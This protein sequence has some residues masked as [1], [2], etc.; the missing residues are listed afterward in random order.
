MFS[1]HYRNNNDF[2]LKQNPMDS[3][4]GRYSFSTTGSTIYPDLTYAIPDTRVGSPCLSHPQHYS[5]KSVARQPFVRHP[6]R[7]N[8]SRI[9]TIFQCTCLYCTSEKISTNAYYIYSSF[10]IIRLR[11]SGALALIIIVQ[12]LGRLRCVLDTVIKIS[13]KNNDDVCA[14]INRNLTGNVADFC[15]PRSLQVLCLAPKMAPT[16][17][18]F[19]P[20]CLFHHVLKMPQVDTSDDVTIQ[21]HHNLNCCHLILQPAAL[22]L[23]QTGY[24]NFTLPVLCVSCGVS[25]IHTPIS[26]TLPVK[27]LGVHSQEDCTCGSE[28]SRPREPPFYDTECSNLSLNAQRSSSSRDN[29]SYNYMNENVLPHGDCVSRDTTSRT[30]SRGMKPSKLLKSRDMRLHCSKNPSSCSD[31]SPRAATLSLKQHKTPPASMRCSPLDV[32]LLAVLLCLTLGSSPARGAPP[33]VSL[34]SLFPKSISIND[35][36]KE[37]SSTLLTFRRRY[38]RIAMNYTIKEGTHSMAYDSPREILD[39]FCKG[40]FPNHVITL[41]NINNPLGMSRRT[42][43]N[44][45]ILKLAEFLGLPII[46]WDSEYVGDSQSRTVQLAPTIEHQAM[47]MASLLERYNW[48]TFT[49]ITTPVAGHSQFLSSFE[50]IV[51]ASV[52]KSLSTPA[53][54]RKESLEILSTIHIREKSEIR[55]QLSKVKGTD[56]RIFLLHSSSVMTLEIIE[57]ANHLE[58][59]GRDYV[60]ILT[61]TAIPNAKHVSKSF[62]IGLMGITFEFDK[63]AMKRV[64]RWG[65]KLWLTA[66]MNMAN[67]RG[68]LA[69]MTIPPKFACNAT[70]KDLFWKDGEILY[71]YMLNASVLNEPQLVFN[72]NGTLTSTELIILNLQWSDRTT[73]STA[74]REVGRWQG[75]GLKMADITWPGGSSVPPTGRPKKTFLRVATLDEVPYVIYRMPEEDGKCEE[76]SLDCYVY[77]RNEKKERMSNMTVLRCCVG[78][79]MDLLKVLSTQLN[80]DFSITEVKDGQW[81]AIK[82]K[83]WNG[84]VKTLLDGEADIVMTSLK[85]NPERAS[86]VRFSVPYLETGIKIIVALRDGAISPTAFLEPYD[87]ASW[88]LILIFSVHATGSSILIFEWLSPYGLN[89]GLTPMR[90]HKF[91][92]FRS[93]WLI[94]AMLFSTSVQTDSPKGIASRFLANIWALFALV[95]LASYTANLAAFM[96]TKE[97][98]YDLS[99]IQDYRLQN[100]YTMNPPFKY[101]TIPNGSTEANIRSNH[102]DMYNYM[103]TYNLP[104][105]KAGITALKQGKIQAFIYDS[106]VLEYWASRDEK[107][108]LLTVGN[109]YAMTGYGVGFPPDFKN[110]WIDKFNKVILKL[111]E[112]GEM[113]R[114]QKFWLAGACDTKKEKGVSNRTLGILNFT[115]AFIL[116]GSGILLGLL[117][118]IFEHFYFKFCRK[119]LRKWDKCGCCALVS[120]SMGKSLQLKDYVDEAMNA[121]SKTRCKDALCEV[122]IWK[123]RHQLDMALLKIDHLQNQLGDFGSDLLMIM[124]TTTIENEQQLDDREHQPI[125]A[126]GMQQTVAI[127]EPTKKQKTSEHAPKFSFFNSSPMDPAELA[128]IRSLELQD[129]GS[130]VER[131]EQLVDHFDKQRTSPVSDHFC[132]PYLPPPPHGESPLLSESVSNDAAGGGSSSYGGETYLGFD[133]FNSDVGSV[134]SISALA[135]RSPAVGSSPGNALRR[136]PSYTSAVG[137]ESGSDA[138]SENSPNISSRVRQY[139]GKKYMGVESTSPVT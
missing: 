139:D 110:P 75:Q 54:S 29:S 68:L 76:K 4:P 62:K 63:E 12:I 103:K 31:H 53:D 86:A 50:N 41:L 37:Q 138:N 135:R 89:R 38:E 59:T 102:I 123:L 47:A 109:R 43:S 67:T 42:S 111:Q 112:N 52:K 87:Y 16:S 122:Q 117:I 137:R 61:T 108:R 51:E 88:S 56:T 114:L 58:L 124:P 69:N 94:W 97:E 95:F 134:R 30:T 78:L 106:S 39:T 136:T 6:L 3:Q 90:E 83:T 93:F 79:S 107:C 14:A 46:S 104:D 113:D 101:A 85:I 91:S 70:Q 13:G 55:S 84:L 99:G 48:T 133:D 10:V 98:F 65:V 115:S 8:S 105:I 73:N 81:G 40:M 49:I 127:R 7:K 9:S 22:N 128:F 121:Y 17:H 15:N 132:D 118:L 100:P 96:I 60:W 33:L 1:V 130:F 71:K 21:N 32:L 66:L 28:N 18:N 11:Y 44:K 24:D 125:K 80:F 35:L 5:A 25:S 119:H 129:A 64:I 26:A 131:F 20:A 126:N 116:L 92:L 23:C 57:E 36:G 45:Y 77:P 34:H 19:H 82:S 2:N 74:W 72:E 120:L 27:V